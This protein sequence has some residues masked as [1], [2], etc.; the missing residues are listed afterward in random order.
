MTRALVCD[1][2]LLVLGGA[3]L[4][5]LQVLLLDT[6]DMREGVSSTAAGA[7]AVAHFPRIELYFHKGMRCKQHLAFFGLPNIKRIVNQQWI[8]WREAAAALDAR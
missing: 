1:R 3:G 8:C 4:P 7:A 5:Q 6:L 2:L